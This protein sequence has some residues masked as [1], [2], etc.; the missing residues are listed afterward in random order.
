M[1]ERKVSTH[2]QMY[3]LIQLPAECSLSSVIYLYVCSHASYSDQAKSDPIQN[4][5]PTTS[6]SRTSSAIHIRYTDSTL[7]LHSHTYTPRSYCLL[8][9]IPLR[10][11]YKHLLIFPFVSPSTNQNEVH[12]L[13]GSIAT[14]CLCNSERDSVMLQALSREVSSEIEELEAG[15]DELMIR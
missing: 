5:N 12:R 14:N 4:L 13:Y 10:H 11:N 2:L 6:L 7:V 15:D 9:F 3:E 8:V 1:T